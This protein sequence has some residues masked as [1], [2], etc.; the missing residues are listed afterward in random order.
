MKH[1]MNKL[2]MMGVALRAAP[3][4]Q[5]FQ[6]QYAQ[7]LYPITFGECPSG[8]FSP[9]D[10]DVRSIDYNDIQNAF[11]AGVTHDK[12]ALNEGLEPRAGIKSSWSGFLA[13]INLLTG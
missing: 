12:W 1:T 5:T 9:S 3:T 7:D 10:S 2:I 11:I 6:I 8:V 13:N 4:H